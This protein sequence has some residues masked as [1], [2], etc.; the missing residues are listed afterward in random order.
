MD[1]P[2]VTMEFRSRVDVLY[3]DNT[4]SLMIG[5][6]LR[7]SRVADSGKLGCMYKQGYDSKFY[8]LTVKGEYP[9]IHISI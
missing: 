9:C 6:K 4:E 2:D 8:F 7:K 5:F 1:A 3:K